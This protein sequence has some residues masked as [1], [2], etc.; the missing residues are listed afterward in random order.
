MSGLEVIGILFN[1]WP[2]LC[3]A[4][5]HYEDALRPFVRYRN[6]SSKVQRIHDELETEKAIFRTECLLLVAATTNRDTASKMLSD[7]LHPSW[8]NDALQK[9]F[10]HQ[11]G[12]LGYSCE[13]VLS[14]LDEKL[15]EISK[16]A[17]E[18]STAASQPADKETIGD[19]KWR[20]R[21]GKK[22]KF[23]MSDL[24]IQHDLE[25]LKKLN[26]TFLT[27]SSQVVRLENIWPQRVDPI[28][29]RQQ[30]Q[31][32]S[33][34]L[35]T[36][37]MLQKA[38]HSLYESLARACTKHTHHFARLNLDQTKL[39]GSSASKAQIRF[40]LA[41]QYVE[42]PNQPNRLAGA[43]K[44][45][46]TPTRSYH[47]TIPVRANANS[48]FLAAVATDSAQMNVPQ[49]PC[50][51]ENNIGIDLQRKIASE[52]LSWFEV[53]ST[54]SDATQFYGMEQTPIPVH[55]P[56]HTRTTN[57][58]VVAD[59]D[60]CAHQV[61]VSAGGPCTCLLRQTTYKHI[62]HHPSPSL[63]AWS[64]QKIFS[65]ANSIASTPSLGWRQE[66]PQFKRL[67]IAKT[68]AMT[69]LRF[70][71]TP[72]LMDSWHSDG[73]YLLSGSEAPDALSEKLHSPF[74][75]VKVASS[76]TKGKTVAADISTAHV[77]PNLILFRLGIMFLELAYSATFKTLR[78]SFL[79]N[80][81]TLPP[82]ESAAD[83]IRARMLADCVGTSLGVD[84]A[85]IVKKCLR[86]DFG[87]G[88]D[89]TDPKLQVRLYEDVV[90]KLEHLEDGFRSLQ[91]PT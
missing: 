30:S 59:S 76:S 57:V 79:F 43:L 8:K 64:Q 17:G 66:M 58:S 87:C 80:N 38:S 77:V 22:L 85:T 32:T 90:C 19:R 65:L 88:E 20:H 82:E 33:Q 48:E 52:M 62:V 21:T 91:A 40:K 84:F 89:L 86:C 68:L 15:F 12:S 23:A 34:V 29:Q 69:V 45:D 24:G 39:V 44:V 31:E 26:R 71:S 50:E 25:E 73:I 5:E 18:L 83:F 35:A 78:A 11:L 3:T 36:S 6:F 55:P 10:S 70:Y 46:F 75:S 63:S 53:E 41:Y 42:P 27:L 7:L 61:E 1:V 37:R 74:I 13:S 47:A 60:F 72:W 4:V 54:P 28:Q 81:M 49:L 67:N 2:V 51:H 14:Q 16:K 56:A 9:K